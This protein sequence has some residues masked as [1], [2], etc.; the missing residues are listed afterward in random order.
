MDFR[1]GIIM[2]SSRIRI[3][4]YLLATLIAIAYIQMRVREESYEYINCGEALFRAT[5]AAAPRD[6]REL[7]M[8]NDCVFR[9]VKRWR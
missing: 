9:G 5:G 4:I 6:K 3:I 8:Y 7:S 2:I 1:R